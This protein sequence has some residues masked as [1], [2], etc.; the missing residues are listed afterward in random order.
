MRV[1]APPMWLVMVTLWTLVIL[2]V[3]GLT[4]CAHAADDAVCKPYASALINNNMS[5][6]WQRAF[7]HCKLLEEDT[8]IPPA[9]GDWRGALNILEPTPPLS[10]IGNTPAGDKPPSPPQRPAVASPPAP[11]QAAAPVRSSA[12]AAAAKCKAAHP[13]GFQG[14]SGAGTYNVLVGKKWVRVPCPLT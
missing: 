11:V 13:S 2:G 9:P 3:Y 12:G 10:E 1:P 8:P 14:N 4:T 6:L 7:N 5:W